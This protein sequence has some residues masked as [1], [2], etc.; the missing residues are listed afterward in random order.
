MAELEVVNEMCQL[1]ID[2]GIC[3]D[4]KDADGVHPV[5]VDDPQDGAPAPVLTDSG[6]DLRPGTVTLTSLERPAGED[7][8]RSRTVVAFCVIGPDNATAKLIIRQIQGLLQPR[9]LW[10]GRNVFQMG[11]I[12]P[13]DLCL[14]F[15]A[16]SRV[17]VSDD[18]YQWDLAFELLIRRDVLAGQP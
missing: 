3:V 4:M 16:P 13:V 15:R 14:P 7:N 6:L 18:G 5:V 17:R 8:S 10:G 9:E 11:A 2:E 12:D 1:L